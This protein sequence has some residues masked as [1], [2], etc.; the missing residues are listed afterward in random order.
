MHVSVGIVLALVALIGVMLAPLASDLLIHT[1]AAPL[2]SLTVGQKVEIA[3]L[4]HSQRTLY[5]RPL[6]W[7]LPGTLSFLAEFSG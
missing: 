5:V 3:R 4:P 1:A 7:P 2:G 6:A